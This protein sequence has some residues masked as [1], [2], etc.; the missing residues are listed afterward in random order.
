MKNDEKDNLKLRVIESWIKDPSILDRLKD[1]LENGE[2][3][4]ADDLEQ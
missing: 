4:E 1:S 2:L 3:V